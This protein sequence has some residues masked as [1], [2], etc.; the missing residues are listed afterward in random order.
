MFE[1][2]SDK[3]Q[4]SFK[5][6][7]GQGT[8]SDENIAEAIR[9]IRL[10]L[11]ES[12]VNLT[13]VNELVEHIRDKAMGT[14]VTTA[15]SPSEQIVKIVR[16]ELVG[17]LGK[18]T[19]RFQK[20]SQPPSVILMAGLQGSGKT[21]T[22]GKLGQWLKKS[23]HRPMLVSVDVYRPAAREQLAIVAKA[24]G[25][26]IYEGKL[27]DGA[28]G[29]DEVL[30]LAKE[31]KRE[32][33][34]FGCDM[35]IVDTAGR[36]QIDAAL[37]D[38]MAQLKKL[39]NPSEILFVADAMTGQDAVKSA[40]AFNDLLTITGAILTKMDGDARGGAALSIR[41]VTGAPI[42]F[43]G[44]GEK[45]DAFEPFHPDRIVSRI[46]GMGDIATLLERAEEKLDKGKA[47]QFARKALSGDGFSL[48]DFRDQLRQIKKMGSMQSI[49]KMLPS[50]GPFAGMAQAAENVDEKQFSRVES[51]IN[52]MTNKE[53]QD[54]E[55]ISGSRRKR[56]AAGS[57]TSVQEV[58]NLLRQ[59]AQM[60][61][62]FKMMGGGGGMK[63]Q[64]R[65]M[66]QMAGKQRFGR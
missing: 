24:I 32:A 39:L 53:R 10:A 50:V 42:K 15:L 49:L 11:L 61:K 65:M 56:I 30:R 41:H 12:D 8:I 1:N 2:L 9:E 3:L 40:K 44:T 52:S 59:Y 28:H 29:T 14:Q 64:Q 57:G 35:L 27:G 43:L 37:M 66:S 4:R 21:T 51:I 38:E 16:D 17:L 20:S 55:L 19:A 45:P 34:N 63:M 5:N 62:M 31:A 60:R 23:G 22:S 47:E 36:N 7:R 54:H 26:N 13:V 25:A 6:L 46:M 58:N 18:D 33:A 48:E